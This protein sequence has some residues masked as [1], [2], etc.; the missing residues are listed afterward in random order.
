MKKIYSL[1]LVLFLGL[2]S[3]EGSD[4]Y[5][6]KWKATDMDGQKFELDFSPTYFTISNAGGK[7]TKYKYTQNSI[8]SENSVE[9]YGI[10]LEDGRGYNIVFPLKDEE[11]GLIFDENG[12][13]MYT[14][15]RKSHMTYEE[16]YKL[17]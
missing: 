4:A 14:I 12:S 5:Q 16:M 9:T 15:G 6:G 3:C 17:E 7:Q 8:K 13:M 1:V 11:K 10:K 2:I